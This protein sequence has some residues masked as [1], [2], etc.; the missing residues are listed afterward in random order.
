MLVS[1]RR[2]LLTTRFPTLVTDL[3]YSYLL[4]AYQ[5]TE[6]HP[7]YRG[8]SNNCQN[9][10][11]FLLQRLSPNSSHSPSS[12][13][14]TLYDLCDTFR[15]RRFPSF[16]R[17]QTVVEA[18]SGIS[19]PPDDSISER[20]DIPNSKA[21]LPQADAEGFCKAECKVKVRLSECAYYSYACGRKN[22]LVFFFLVFFANWS[23]RYVGPPRR[24]GLNDNVTRFHKVPERDSRKILNI[25]IISV[26]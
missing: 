3:V 8:F 9:F 12:I 23:A 24:V 2:A 20:D 11:L 21:F 18:W 17:G 5:I 25:S 1:G 16:S 14:D 19:L 22:V 4:L 26:I 15:F 13:Q 10:V 7:N 6:T